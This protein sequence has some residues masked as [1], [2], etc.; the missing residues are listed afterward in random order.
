MSLG[1]AVRDEFTNDSE[2]GE[3]DFGSV[4]RMPGDLYGTIQ[5]IREAESRDLI[6][7]ED[8]ESGADAIFL[9]RFKHESWRLARTAQERS[10]DDFAPTVDMPRSAILANAPR[11]L[12]GHCSGGL[13]GRSWLAQ[14]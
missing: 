13:T 2:G 7:L 11:L 6:R 12:A 4:F 5:A 1:N 9:Q 10:T 14:P 3:S 8:L